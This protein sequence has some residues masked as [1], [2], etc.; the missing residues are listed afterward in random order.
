MAAMDSAVVFSARLDELGLGAFKDK[1]TNAGWTSFADFAF[2]TSSFKEPDP[3]VFAK[4]VLELILE[5]SMLN[6]WEGRAVFN[7]VNGA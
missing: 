6:R 3:E 7:Q 4:E 2:A 5:S 1:F